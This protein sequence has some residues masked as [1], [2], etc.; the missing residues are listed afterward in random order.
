MPGVGFGDVDLGVQGFGFRVIHTT[1]LKPSPQPLA[2]P[3][4]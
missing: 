3:N 1:N 2:K 4:P